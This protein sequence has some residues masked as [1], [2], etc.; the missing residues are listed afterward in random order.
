MNFMISNLEYLAETVEFFC[1]EF[2]L[3]DI[4]WLIGKH[5]GFTTLQR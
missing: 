2:T 3:P 5:Y 1:A 4:K